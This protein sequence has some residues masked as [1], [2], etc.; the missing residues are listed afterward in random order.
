MPYAWHC[1]LHAYLYADI[2]IFYAAG[3]YVTS[4]YVTKPKWNDV[5]PHLVDFVLGNE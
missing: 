3:A 4:V 1:Y 5:I 2:C